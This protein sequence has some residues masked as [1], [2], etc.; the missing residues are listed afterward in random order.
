LTG[1]FNCVFWVKSCVVECKLS[2]GIL[3]IGFILLN[4]LVAGYFS[5]RKR[6]LLNGG[7]SCILVPAVGNVDDFNVFAEHYFFPPNL[8][9]LVDA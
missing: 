4:F 3:A 6:R 2:G 8:K 9:Q 7:A 5:N 1:A